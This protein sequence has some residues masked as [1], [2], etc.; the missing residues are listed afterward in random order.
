MFLY[1]LDKNDFDVDLM[2]D[3][4]LN[5]VFYCLCEVLP[6]I[7]ILAVLRKLPPSRTKSMSAY[8]PIEGEQA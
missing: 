1:I 7:C 4:L 3:H 5:I 6:A 8:T 2:E